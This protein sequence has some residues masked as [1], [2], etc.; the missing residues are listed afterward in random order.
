MSFRALKTPARRV[1]NACMSGRTHPRGRSP[2]LGTPALLGALLLPGCG[3]DGETGPPA[4]GAATPDAGG[5]PSRIAPEPGAPDAVPP[6]PLSA[7]AYPDGPYAD[8]ARRAAEGYSGA[9]APARIDTGNAGTLMAAVRSGPMSDATRRPGSVPSV[10]RRAYNRWGDVIGEY[11]AVKAGHPAAW[12]SLSGIGA[13]ESTASSGGGSSPRGRGRPYAEPWWR[14][15]D[16]PGNGGRACVD[17]GAVHWSEPLAVDGATASE[18]RSVTFHGCAVAGGIVSG[19]VRLRRDPLPDGRDAYAVA[20]DGL[21]VDI[22]DEADEGE[23]AARDRY[24]VTGVDA[25]PG[26]AGCE[27]A[28]PRHS[29]LHVEADAPERSFFVE[30]LETSVIGYHAD[31]GLCAADGILSNHWRGR[32]LHGAHGAVDVA[33]PTHLAHLSTSEYF[34]RVARPYRTLRTDGPQ[35]RGHLVLKGGQGSETSVIYRNHSPFEAVSGVGG[36]EVAYREV[37][38]VEVHSGERA[39]SLFRFTIED[40]WHGVLGDLADGDGDGAPNAWERLR[41]LDATDGA[42]AFED[43]DE[44]GAS[45]ADEARRATSP[46]RADPRNQDADERIVLSVSAAPDYVLQMSAGSSG[47]VDVIERDDLRD[48]ARVSVPPP[49]FAELRPLRHRLTLSIDGT[50]R[51][52]SG[53]TLAYMAPYGYSAPAGCALSADARR[54]SCDLA[55]ER[56]CDGFTIH[57]GFYDCTEGGLVPRSFAVVDDT[58]EPYAITARLLPGPL[59]ASPENDAVAVE[60]PA[61]P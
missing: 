5:D 38:D 16:E 25:W 59:D 46:T 61:V 41:G 19:P 32:L 49:A 57:G 3:P 36:Y 42:D 14:V 53:R 29:Y 56:R 51:F 43:V 55:A 4:L 37:I 34:D 11:R 20:Y 60:R 28:R 52:M 15:F 40:A 47:Q 22:A 9:R 54:L 6:N 1:V 17:G 10:V 26:G 45:A 2:L 13:P 48:V 21:V 44:D 33:T 31:P 35:F 24:T 23:E 18:E 39:P 7:Y 8:V 50:A 12:L 27:L 58:G 30:N